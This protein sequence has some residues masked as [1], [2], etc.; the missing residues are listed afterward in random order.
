VFQDINFTK[1][2]YLECNFLF[3]YDY[4]EKESKKTE[5]GRRENPLAKNREARVSPNRRDCEGTNRTP[6]Q[7]DP[8]AKNGVQKR[9]RNGIPFML[10]YAEKHEFS[11]AFPAIYCVHSESRL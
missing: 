10:L 9:R 11:L 8:S 3:R 4:G 2:I 7:T 6:K 1:E 5:K